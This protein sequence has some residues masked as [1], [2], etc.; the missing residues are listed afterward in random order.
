M[1]A[2]RSKAHRELMLQAGL[3][4]SDIDYRTALSLQFFKNAP[5]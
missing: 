3:L 2:E 1:T 4:K 5:N